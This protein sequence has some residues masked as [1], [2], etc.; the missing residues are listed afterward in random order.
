MNAREEQLGP[1]KRRVRDSFV[2]FEH[3]EGSRVINASEAPNVLRSM[4]YNPTEAQAQ[5][6]RQKLE[7][8]GAVDEEGKVALEHFEGVAAGWILDT[9]EALTRDDLHA[10]LRAFR[11]LDSEGKGYMQ[12]ETLQVRGEPRPVVLV[13]AAVLLAAP[14]SRSASSGPDAVQLIPT[15]TADCPRH[16]LPPPAWPCCRRC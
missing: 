1:L 14:S 11:A 2:V 13:P 16:H 5:Q 12:A 8:A 7:M 9:E 6:L 4:G 15:P 10:L 3:R